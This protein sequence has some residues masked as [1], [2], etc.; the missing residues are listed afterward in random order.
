MKNIEAAV[1]L[2]DRGGDERT[3]YL[4]KLPD[5]YKQIAIQ[6]IV[7]IEFFEDLGSNWSSDPGGKNPNE[8]TSVSKPRESHFGTNL[9]TNFDH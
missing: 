4:S 3:D 7:G 2:R 5:G 9:H 8:T 6:S 1:K